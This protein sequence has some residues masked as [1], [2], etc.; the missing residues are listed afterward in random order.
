MAN[1]NSMRDAP[2]ADT[3]TPRGQI[4]GVEDHQARADARMAE[5]RASMGD[6]EFDVDNF[7]DRL[8]AAEPPGWSYNWKAASVY[9]KENPQYIS[10]VQRGGWSPVPASR[11]RDL[12]YPEYRGETIIV[13]GLL[14]MERPRELTTKVQMREKKL[15]ELAV[16]VKE[17]QAKGAPLSEGTVREHELLPN[18]IHS[19]T[20]RLTLNDI[21]E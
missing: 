10:G 19:E 20:R 18:R 14:L 6:D 15:A 4:P 21:P 7:K 1:P 13:D 3:A 9:G 8:F 17:E 11:H 5:L 16:R 12:I 2:R